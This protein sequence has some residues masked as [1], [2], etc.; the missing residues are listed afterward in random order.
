VPKLPQQ[1]H[2]FNVH[3][4]SNDVFWMVPLGEVKMTTR[5]FVSV[6]VSKHQLDV[7][8]RPSGER[9]AVANDHRGVTRLVKII[10]WSRAERIVLEASDGFEKLLQER[11]GEKGF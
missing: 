4:D 11:L 10:G 5:A 6:D 7:A 1:I 9:L 8:F 2:D 3:I